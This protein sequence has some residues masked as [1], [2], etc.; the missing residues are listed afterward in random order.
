LPAGLGQRAADLDHVGGAALDLEIALDIGLA[1]VVEGGREQVA[2]A[3]RAGHPDLHARL[4]GGQVDVLAIPQFH[5]QRQVDLVAD[6]CSR[7]QL[8]LIEHAYSSGM[9]WPEVHPGSGLQTCRVQ[10]PSS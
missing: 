8:E 5:A 6:A 2:Q 10:L 4:V 3:A 1:Q 7:R 9:A